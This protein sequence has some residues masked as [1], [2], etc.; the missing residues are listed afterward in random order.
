MGAGEPR[1][2]ASA[3]VIRCV[4]PR[5]R[6]GSPSTAPI[7]GYGRDGDGHRLSPATVFACPI[8]HGATDCGHV[9]GASTK[10]NG[11]A[12]LSLQRGLWRVLER[13]VDRSRW[14]VPASIGGWALGA[15]LGAAAGYFDDGLDIVI[16]PLVAAATSGAVL[17][18][19]VQSPSGPAPGSAD[20]SLAESVAAADSTKSST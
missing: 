11:T 17:V 3:T 16:G 19:L 4:E 12:H 8:K 9:V 7:A 5:S 1:A 13:R 6:A 10:H 14:W 18:A 20:A 2:R 15:A